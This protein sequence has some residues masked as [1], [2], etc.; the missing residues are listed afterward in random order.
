MNNCTNS[1]AFGIEKRRATLMQIC[2]E[3]V[4]NT[5]DVSSS[6]AGLQPDPKDTASVF[7]DEPG[8]PCPERLSWQYEVWLGVLERWL[9]DISSAQ[10]D[11]ARSQV[12]MMQHWNAPLH[13]LTAIGLEE[14]W[15][16]K[17]AIK[18]DIPRHPVEAVRAPLVRSAQ[19]LVN[20]VLQG[21]V[22]TLRTIQEA[23]G[24][25]MEPLKEAIRAM[26]EHGSVM[27]AKTH[28]GSH[29]WRRTDGVTLQKYGRVQRQEATA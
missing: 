22:A 29:G 23:T 26:R 10:T 18:G 11:C 27:P 13:F 15:V 12:S 21:G 16:R 1:E 17:M 8:V 14:R 28:K 20:D 9:I 4:W 7:E 3:Q 2:R 5:L 19:Q 6:I 25:G 24:L